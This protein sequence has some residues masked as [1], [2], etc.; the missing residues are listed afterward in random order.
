MHKTECLCALSQWKQLVFRKLFSKYCLPEPLCKSLFCLTGF[1]QLLACLLPKYEH[2][3]APEGF[4]SVLFCLPFLLPKKKS[5]SGSVQVGSG[6]DLW[7]KWIAKDYSSFSS[8]PV[9]FRGP[10]VAASPPEGHFQLSPPPMLAPGGL[11]VAQGTSGVLWGCC[12]AVLVPVHSCRCGGRAPTEMCAHLCSQ[13]RGCSGA[14]QGT[15]LAALTYLCCST[16]QRSKTM[17]C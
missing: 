3:G 1:F 12:A 17:M 13:D 2:K 16:A 11:E 6:W 15:E 7:L 5:V 8:W 9:L 4:F 14:L 10:P